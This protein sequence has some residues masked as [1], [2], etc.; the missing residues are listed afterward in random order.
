MIC[1]LSVSHVPCTV[2]PHR[3]WNS[4]EAAWI[5]LTV[6]DCFL[7]LMLLTTF[8]YNKATITIRTHAIH[9]GCMHAAISLRKQVEGWA[10][11]LEHPAADF[12]GEVCCK[13][14][15]RKPQVAEEGSGGKERRGARLVM[16]QLVQTSLGGSLEEDKMQTTSITFLVSRNVM[17]N[18]FKYENFIFVK[19]SM[20]TNWL[21]MS[22]R[23]EESC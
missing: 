7:A 19:T 11:E 20:R 2:I 8:T 9:R 5:W 14:K 16:Q 12:G 17:K 23:L 10:E 15:R 6:E 21:Y 1:C 13:E 22:W 4:M 3:R 18:T